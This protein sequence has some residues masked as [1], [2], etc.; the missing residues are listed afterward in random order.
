MR[1]SDRQPPSQPRVESGQLWPGGLATAV[2]AALIALVG[3]LICRWLFNIPILAPR[4]DGAYGDVHT[5]GFVIAAAVAA[6]VATGI[7]HLLLLSTPRPLT[8]FNWIVGLVTL[9]LVV[10]PF[11]TS[12]PLPEKVA[13]AAVDLV[14]GI[15]IASLINGVAA[16]SV[17]RRPGD[18]GYAT[19]PPGG[20]GYDPG[21]R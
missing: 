12:A 1:P 15:A 18:R 2:V 17:R 10:F 4:K 5:T 16:R 7:V 21:L 9:V 6:L 19:I 11:S 20:S 13:T 8:F 14:L 3:V